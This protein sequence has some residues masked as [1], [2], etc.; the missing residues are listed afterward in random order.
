MD[1]VYSHI[2]PTCGGK[3]NVNTERQMYECPFCGVTFDY[4]Y[5][6]EES[7]LSIASEALKNDEFASAES[8][9]DFMLVKEPDNF[10]ALRGKALIAMDIPKIDCISDLDLYT[11]INYGSAYK[12]IDRAIESSKPQDREYFTVMKG[13]VESG[14]EYIEDKS[15]LEAQKTENDKSE[16]IL[17]EVI[18]ERDSVFIYA[19]D[20]FST[21]KAII[22]TLLCYIICLLIVFLGFKFVTRNP[23]SKAE[24]L[25]RYTTEVSEDENFFDAVITYNDYQKAL[26]REEQRKIKYE[27]WEKDHQNSI[28]TLIF[29]L[30]LATVAYVVIVFALFLGGR[31]Y[32]AM[33]SKKQSIVDE[34]NDKIKHLEEKITE[35]KGRINQGYKRLLELH[36][37]NE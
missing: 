31:R 5:F 34:Q 24:D 14:H 11:K 22:L 35:T 10:E 6:R 28:E 33:I 18:K 21:K 15:K 4:D 20:K 27:A 17:Y 3:L 1:S 8:A 2:C 12:E 7:V 25:S 19:S 30:S 23:Y 29:I 26:E 37:V 9:Y 36:P 13:I 16:H 32:N